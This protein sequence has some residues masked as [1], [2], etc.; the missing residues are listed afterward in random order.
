[1]SAILT[2]D[3]YPAAGSGVLRPQFPFPES[4]R[5]L[6]FSNRCLAKR[7]TSAI[8]HQGNVIYRSRNVAGNE[9]QDSLLSPREGM[10]LTPSNRN[11]IEHIILKIRCSATQADFFRYPQKRG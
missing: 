7:R 1:M 8:V 3:P 9:L 2:V 5:W 10:G 11:R 6:C 4:R